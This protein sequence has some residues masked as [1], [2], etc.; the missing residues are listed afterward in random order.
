MLKQFYFKQFSLAQ[1]HSLDL[2]DPY[3][4][5]Y[6]VLPLRARVGQGVMAMKWYSA[7]PKTPALLVHDTRW[8]GGLN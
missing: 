5:L 2:F 8:G 1:V 4:G 6:Q 3:I 7:F